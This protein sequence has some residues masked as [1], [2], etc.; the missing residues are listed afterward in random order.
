MIIACGLVGY[1]IFPD[2]YF[3]A[4]QNEKTLE[5]FSPLIN[6]EI[7]ALIEQESD[8]IIFVTNYT[9]KGL[10]GAEDKSV[11]TLFDNYSDF[12]LT[13]ESIQ[14]RN[15]Y[16]IIPKHSDHE[17]MAEVT[18]KINTGDYLL[19]FEDASWIPYWFIKV[20]NNT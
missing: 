5:T 3:I 4:K 10:P 11:I 8:D 19:L 9:I 16:I 1:F 13:M 2:S 14:Q 18:A 15:L 12:R 7:V 17:I 20:I 6:Q